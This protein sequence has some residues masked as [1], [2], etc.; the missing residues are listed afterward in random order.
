MEIREYKEVLI[1]NI[2]ENYKCSMCG[3]CCRSK[4]RIDVD[5]NSYRKVKKMLEKN[6]EDISEYIEESEGNK[7]VKFSDGYC[8]FINSDKSC[9]IHGEF[10]WEYLCN[11]C[12]VYPRILHLTSRGVEI[13]FVY[14]CPTLVKLLLSE[15]KFK[16]KRIKKED[17]FFMPPQT[18]SFIIPENNLKFSM[19]SRYYELEE[20]AIEILNQDRDLYSKIS[21]LEEVLYQLSKVEDIREVNF[22]SIIQDLDNYKIEESDT[23][24]LESAMEIF[25]DVMNY[26]GK[27][28]S[29][30]FE[31]YNF[32]IKQSYLNGDIVADRDVFQYSY[33][34]TSDKFNELKKF[35]NDRYD[36]ILRN[37]FQTQLFNKG[38]YENIGRFL[39]RS[40]ILLV[41]QKI[42]ILLNAKYLG[43]ELTVE[44]LLYVIR[45][46]E[47]DFSHSFN[48]FQGY[49]EETIIK[50]NMDIR[51]FIKKLLV[52]LK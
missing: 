35:W 20:M 15:E 44:E 21:Y 1:P 32:L 10:G 4:W 11:T 37:Y 14:S 2:L 24:L 27:E 9:R 16:I 18:M 42:G 31:K 47:N 17:Y 45:D 46:I 36:I 23:N 7:I 39:M 48:F 52:I 6:K 33:R 8:S 49:W 40:V 3:E 25:T 50:N 12:K 30:V 34:L 51:E 5:D 43:R 38:M 26:K 28:N 13:S 22:D 29:N 19:L 41:I